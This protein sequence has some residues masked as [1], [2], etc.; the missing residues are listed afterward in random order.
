MKDVVALS[1]HAE[2]VSGAKS[3]SDFIFGLAEKERLT[4]YLMIFQTACEP[5]KGSDG[6]GE[7]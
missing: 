1:A 6:T 3:H 5:Q 7:G 2:L 4:Y